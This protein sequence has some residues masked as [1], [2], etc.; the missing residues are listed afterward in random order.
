MEDGTR[1][2]TAKSVFDAFDRPREGKSKEEQC[3]TNM[4]SFLDANN[5]QF[6]VGEDLKWWTI[7]IKYK[8]KSGNEAGGY[9]AKILPAICKVYLDAR[10]QMALYFY[11]RSLIIT[12]TISLRIGFIYNYSALVYPH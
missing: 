4:P 6:F 12:F 8:T 1:V 11:I 2:L 5:L 3:V 10:Q 9:D 7:P